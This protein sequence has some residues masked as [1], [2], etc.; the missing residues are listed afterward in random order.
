[1]A[2]KESGMCEIDDKVIE[3]VQIYTIMSLSL[4]TSSGAKTDQNRYQLCAMLIEEILRHVV[5]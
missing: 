1:M 2:L 3:N 5:F 4:L